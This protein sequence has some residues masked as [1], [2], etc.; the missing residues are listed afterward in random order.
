VATTT[1]DDFDTLRIVRVGDVLRVFIDH[2][3]SD[4]NAVDARLHHDLTLLMSRLRDE[5]QARAVVLTGG[6]RAF[7]AGG[8]YAW[9]PQLRE[10]VRAE[11]LRRDARRMIL[12]LLDVELPVIAAVNGAA[13]GLG[14]TIALFC[15]IILMADDATIGDPH[16]RL[17]IVA[18]DGGA[19]AWPLA[20]GPARAKQYLLTGDPL[21]AKEAERIGLVNRVVPAADL[22][23]EAMA[24]A[25]RLAA[26]APLALR[27]TKAAVN[28]LIKD[29]L[30]VSFERSMAAEML[31]MLSA[32]HVEAMNAL[33]ERRPPRFEGR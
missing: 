11:E 32:D 4:I 21:A 2:P 27:H 25:A 17:G 28:A 33:T 24:L 19:V 23:K 6:R 13:I 3:D 15:D 9:F 16:V 31:T 10:P 22:D 7:C 8:D 29:A 12:D 26:G 1:S 18:G 5:Q 20:L 30:N 14:A